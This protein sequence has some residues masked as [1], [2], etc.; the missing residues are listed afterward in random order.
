MR[1]RAPSQYCRTPFIDPMQ[2][3]RKRKRSKKNVPEEVKVD[4]IIDTT[5]LPPQ[6][7]EGAGENGPPPYNAPGLD[8]ELSPPEG[9]N[10]YINSKVEIE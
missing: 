8:D 9:Y 10:Q 6:V 7:Q 4:P 5:L 3:Y 1:D 2:Q